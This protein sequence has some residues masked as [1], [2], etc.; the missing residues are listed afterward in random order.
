MLLMNLE[1]SLTLCPFIHTQMLPDA[2]M[3]W[4]QL[5]QGMVLSLKTYEQISGKL[6]LRKRLLLKFGNMCKVLASKQ[7]ENS[8]FT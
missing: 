3:D 1:M 6:I 5:S 8:F 4:T 7:F 2:E